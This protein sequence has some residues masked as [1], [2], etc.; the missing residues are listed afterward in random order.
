MIAKGQTGAT[1][2]RMTALIA[3]LA[4]LLSS[5]A[6][7]IEGSGGAPQVAVDADTSADKPIVEP[8]SQTPPPTPAIEAEIL[9]NFNDLGR[10]FLDDRRLD[11]TVEAEI[12]R[13][14]N[15]LRRE[16]LD[17]QARYIDWWLM[18]LGVI[19]PI[20]VF[21]ISF[22]TVQRSRQIETDTRQIEI[23]ARQSEADARKHAEEAERLVK[24][25][26]VRRDEAMMAKDLSAEK[27]GDNPSEAART[28]VNVQE[29]PA[30]S[31]IARAIAAAGLLQREGK[32]EQAI[33][34]WRSI[35]T[36]AGEED[37]QLQARAWFS[38]AY[39]LSQGGGADSEA[40]VDA[41]TKAIELDP[42]SAAAYN[43]RGNAK[44]DLDQYQAAL[45]DLDRAIELDPTYAAAYS[46]RGIAKRNLGRPEAAF[47]DL[48]RAIELDPTSAAA[49][50]NRGYANIVFG[51]P[52]AA[53]ADLDRA[54]ELDPTSDAAYD[55]RGYAKEKLGRINEA[56]A[57]YQIALALAQAAGDK[58]GVE[59]VQRN[60]NRLDTNA[61]P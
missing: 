40:V 13:R 57:D 21:I 47:V 43:N 38:I 37:R 33:E 60:L 61:E 16:S 27:V 18:G 17:V 3:L 41:Y 6:F 52:A 19:I 8:S 36:I 58:K 49:Y 22:L 4:L 1:M 48:D 30:A 31:P 15:D 10:E 59:I 34:K 42:T 28:A 26:R 46:N 25:I 55:S 50:N 12:Q 7:G 51:Q 56:R 14:F 45:V 23:G 2:P 29:D 54:I 5:Q 39:L 44:N 24:D 11:A 35:A 32:I 53:L 9:Q 20:V